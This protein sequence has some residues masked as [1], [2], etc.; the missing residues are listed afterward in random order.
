MENGLVEK[1]FFRVKELQ[2]PFWGNVAHAI[3]KNVYPGL[4]VKCGA[5][6]KA[7]LRSRTGNICNRGGF[8]I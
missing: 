6:S 4:L 2:A 3:N 8:N 5:F 7:V 1:R